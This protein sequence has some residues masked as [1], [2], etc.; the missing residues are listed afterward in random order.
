MTREGRMKHLILLSILAISI[1]AHSSTKSVPKQEE[2]NACDRYN[3]IYQSLIKECN[4]KAIKAL[5]K[6]RNLPFE[7]K[8]TND[9]KDNNNTCKLTNDIERPGMI[10]TSLASKEFCPDVLNVISDK[11]S[12]KDYADG[13]M[14]GFTE[15]F[16]NTLIKLNEVDKTEKDKKALKKNTEALNKLMLTFK[17]VATRINEDCKKGTKESCETLKELSK[18]QDKLTAATE[19]DCKNG[20]KDSCSDTEVKEQTDEEY[21]KSPEYIIDQACPLKFELE[22]YET[23]LKNEKEIGRISGAVNATT[24]R[25][26]GAMIVTIKP[27]LAEWE[28]A[29]L[30]KAKRKINL[31]SCVRSDYFSE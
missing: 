22:R 7:E 20:N 11:I 3:G 29:Y 4:P 1:K 30:K 14:D 2:I 8:L 21:L 27:K 16:F 6:K 19:E 13:V 24:L 10:L 12:A 17:T 31:K 26:A 18:L 28:K 23:I 9:Q 15:K 25:N 5:M